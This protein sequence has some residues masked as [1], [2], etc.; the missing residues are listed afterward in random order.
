MTLSAEALKVVKGDDVEPSEHEI[1]FFDPDGTNSEGGKS[2]TSAQGQGIEIPLRKPPVVASAAAAS[3]SKAESL[4]LPPKPKQETA[5]GGGTN[6]YG[7]DPEMQKKLSH[8]T[9]TLDTADDPFALREG[10]TLLWKDVNMTLVSVNFFLF[11]VCL[12]FL[13]E[14]SFPYLFYLFLES[15]FIHLFSKTES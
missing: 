9:S 11:F 8:H 3:T 14:S 10:K 2:S 13:D 12:N 5:S 1:V 4:P 15:D 7:G 6:G